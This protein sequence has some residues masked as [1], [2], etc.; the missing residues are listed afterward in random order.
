MKTR[1]IVITAM[2]V[3]ASVLSYAV[4]SKDSQLVVVNPKTSNV[5]KVIYKSAGQN[6]VSLKVYNKQGELVFSDNVYSSNGF[7]RP[8]NFEGMESG[9]Y[10]VELKSGNTVNEQ[11]FFYAPTPEVTS[12]EATGTLK[13]IHV[14]KLNADNKYL[15]AFSN[16]GDS[17]V[18]VKIYDGAKELVLNTS[19]NIS[20][21]KGIVYS[22][23][24]VAGVPSFEVTGNKG[25]ITVIK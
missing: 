20:G 7:I 3:L 19:M 25:V 22:L 4:D 24:D 23:K 11:S 6:T 15:V 2:M 10:K 16:T 1:Q 5:F 13:S 17:R 18:N 9:E 14:S 8:L 12:V 21:D